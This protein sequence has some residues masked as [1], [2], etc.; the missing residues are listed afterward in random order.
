MLLVLRGLFIQAHARPYPTQNQV[1][2]VVFDKAVTC[3]TGALSALQLWS[4]FSLSSFLP[5]AGPV[6]LAESSGLYGL[7]LLCVAD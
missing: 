2:C 1:P 6:R 5:R 3:G 4:P 7:V